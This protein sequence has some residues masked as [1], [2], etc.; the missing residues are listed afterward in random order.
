MSFVGKN[1]KKQICP[2]NFLN[3]QAVHPFWTGDRTEKT[4]YF[5]SDKVAR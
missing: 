5:V 2:Q 1:S 4:F 3:K